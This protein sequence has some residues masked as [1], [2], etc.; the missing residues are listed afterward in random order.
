MLKRPPLRRSSMKMKHLT[1]ACLALAFLVTMPFPA[2]VRAAAIP[3]L[4]PP[5]P[6]ALVLFNGTN[7]A[8]WVNAAEEAVNWPVAQDALTVNP[9]GNT[10]SIHTLSVFH[11]F[12][13]HAEFLVPSGGNSGIYLQGRYEIQI[14]ASP[15]NGSLGISDCGAIFGMRAPDVN[16][17]LGTNIWQSFDMVFRAARW[18]EGAKIAD[19]R[20][21]LDWNGVRVHNEVAITNRTGAG[22]AETPGAGKLL[23]QDLGSRVRFR[24]IW[25]LPVPTVLAGP[26]L[27]PGNGHR[28]YLLDSNNWSAAEA[29][30]VAL[31]GHLATINDLAE[32][33]WLLANL[34]AP[35]RALWI[36]LT[37]QAVQGQ[38]RWSSGEAVTYLNWA[39]GEPNNLFSGT[40]H[41]TQVYPPD[42]ARAGLWNDA[43]DRVFAPLSPGSEQPSFGV[44][45]I[46]SPA[47]NLVWIPPGKFMM[48]SANDEPGHNIGFTEDPQT[49]VT[50]TRGFWMGKYEVTQGEFLSVMNFNPSHFTNELNRPVEQVSWDEAGD[51]CR[52]WTE[53]ERSTGPLPAGFLYRLPTEAEW[54]YSCRAGTTTSFSFG[55]NVADLDLYGWY[56]SNSGCSPINNDCS[57]GS[58]R[59]VGLKLPN[60]WGLY[61]MHGNVGEFVLDWSNPYPG[62]S[63][64]DPRGPLTGS[65]NIVRGPAWDFG[66]VAT[67]SASRWVYLRGSSDDS[68]GFR[69]V[70][71]GEPTFYFADFEA[72]AG[73]EWSLTKTS[74]TPLGGRRFLGDFSN[75]VVRL[76]LSNLPRHTTARVTFDLFVIRSW[77]GNGDTCCGPDVWSIS[78]EGGQTLLQTTFSNTADTANRQAYPGSFTQ[79][80]VPPQTGAVEINTLGFPYPSTGGAVRDA[81]YHISVP[82][83]HTSNS[84]ALLF[85]AARLQALTNESWGLD[86]VSIQLG[87]ENVPPPASVFLVEPGA[88]WKYLDNGSNQGT[89]WITPDFNDSTW[90]AGLAELGYGDNNSTDQRPEVTVVSFG[91]NA[92]AKYITTYFRKAFIASNITNITSLT[93]GLLRDDGAIVYLNGLEIFRSNLPNG[94]V[95]F[96]TLATNAA[97]DGKVFFTTSVN[98]GLLVEGTNVL[99][100]EIHQQSGTSSDIS[101]DLYLNASL[102]SNPTTN[103]Q[104]AI[105]E[106]SRLVSLSISAAP[107]QSILIDRASSLAPPIDW[108]NWTNLILPVSPY[109]LADPDSTNHSQR[110]YRVRLP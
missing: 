92:N 87:D 31:G 108:T 67:R 27:N 17:G 25:C 109:T 52:R 4:S 33:Q 68:I 37:D 44:A 76:S 62:G 21:T 13:L 8:A 104:L 12:Q 7:T 35:G 28:Y 22:D 82:F 60:P 63:V 86:N 24:N 38:F 36:G 14:F 97:D 98:P 11:D 100:V 91:P 39:P 77:D 93:A 54:E 51:F 90:A 85:S 18:S 65:A 89:T 103:L 26:I 29:E 99:A 105:A 47:T 6:G 41:F 96:S 73:P 70:L 58:T 71:A 57:Q 107:G 30:A 64:T 79:S 46:T 69:V 23:L 3:N 34:G 80:S 61:D 9:Q 66:D 32:Q 84:L 75:E 20:V 94:P 19:A 55:T 78:E 15:T 72:A 83:K 106:A 95:S 48:G 40:E 43:R 81:V 102:R 10:N 49:Q 50:L 88:T 2:R 53:R 42:H 5:P 56:Y 45:E 1:P 74:V 101:F 59:A 16:A 110:F